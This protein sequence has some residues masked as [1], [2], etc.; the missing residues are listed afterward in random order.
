[1][2][3]RI[4]Y[5]HGNGLYLNIT[6]RCTYHCTFC[7]RDS[8]SAFEGNPLWLSQEPSAAD[9]LDAIEGMG[10]GTKYSEI[11]FCGFGEP[12]MRLDVLLEV[13]R[14]V[15][16]KWGTPVRLN[17]NGQGSLVAGRDISADLK[18]LVDTVSV[19]LN[20]PTAEEYVAVTRPAHGKKTFQAMLDFASAC[21]AR[22]IDVV[23]TVVDAIGPDKVEE[24]RKVA[25]GLGVRFRV[26]EYIP[27]EK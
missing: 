9:V 20:A 12:T 23:M 26:R 18:G 6:N 21:R 16:Q 17:T 13:A 5:A 19:S 22:G 14:G 24:S 10:G 15:K 27:T 1:M 4:A 7:L 25:E 8:R 3:G 11:V 2:N